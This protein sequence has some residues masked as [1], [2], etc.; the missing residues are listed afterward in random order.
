M[1][2]GSSYPSLSR[3]PYRPGITE[4]ILPDPLYINNGKLLTHQACQHHQR[5]SHV[6]LYFLT[7]PSDFIFITFSVSVIVVS[8]IYM[9]DIISNFINLHKLFIN[10]HKYCI[11]LHKLF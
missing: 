7:L 3:L 6:R 10:L 2:A 4:S 11:T 1:E 9:Q 8:K 5:L